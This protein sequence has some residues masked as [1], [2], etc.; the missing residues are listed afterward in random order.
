MGQKNVF[1]YTEYFL[2]KEN[3]RVIYSRIE[4]VSDNDKFF[5]FTI[6][7]INYEKSEKEMIE[8]FTNF[9]KIQCGFNNSAYHNVWFL[10]SKKYF[11][12]DNFYNFLASADWV[13]ACEIEFFYKFKSVHSDYKDFNDFI[14]SNNLKVCCAKELKELYKIYCEEIDKKEFSEEELNKMAKYFYD[15]FAQIYDKLANIDISFSLQIILARIYHSDKDLY[16]KLLDFAC[17]TH[18]KRTEE[19]ADKYFY[20]FC[21]EVLD[22]YNE[23]Y[24]YEKYLLNYPDN[25]PI[26]SR[27]N[28][29]MFCS[30][31]N[32]KWIN[33]FFLLIMKQNTNLIINFKRH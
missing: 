9:C 22:C 14:I 26:M 4:A 23:E 12:C 30:L 13:C 25:S 3:K 15:N 33:N 28:G 32:G 5:E 27:K 18:K 24:D 6:D 21:E 20:K 31:K 16:W 11:Y 7:K 29:N 8:S 1:I 2:D 10:E 19:W 17:K